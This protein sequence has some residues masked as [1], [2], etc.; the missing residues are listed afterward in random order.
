MTVTDRE[1]RPLGALVSIHTQRP[2]FLRIAHT[3]PGYPCVTTLTG[4]G[5]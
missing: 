2:D 3:Q 4:S 1:H 5:A